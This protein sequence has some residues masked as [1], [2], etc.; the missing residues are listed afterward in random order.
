MIAMQYKI[1][2]PSDYPMERIENRIREKGHLLDG[3]PGLMFKAYLY[4]RKDATSYQN[5]VNSYAPFYVWRDH[6]SMVVFLESEGFKA[7]CEQFGRPKVEVWFVDGEPVA[8]AEYQSFACID[9]QGN[10]HSD[11]RGI[12]FSS[13]EEVSVVW[14]SHSEIMND[15]AG[16]VYA[17]VYVAR[18]TL[19]FR[20]GTHQS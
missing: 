9:H 11:V 19:L 17:V 6:E 15:L 16:E 12:N 7:L 5:S 3:F 8:L 2:L 1:V 18:G 20:S 13:W 14:R 4:S 10:Q